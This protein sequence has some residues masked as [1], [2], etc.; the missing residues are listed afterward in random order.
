[1]ETLT[2]SQELE[3]DRGLPPAEA[4]IAIDGVT[5]FLI[6]GID[7]AGKSTLSCSLYLALKE[8][9]INVSLHEI[10]PWSDTH[11]PILGNKPWSQRQKRSVIPAEE[12]REYV[13]RFKNDR[14]SIV[15]GD[16]QGRA[17]HQGSYLLKEAAEHGILV[18]RDRTEKDLN[19]PHRQY[20]GA[21]EDLFRQ[22]L[23][24]T[25]IRIRSIRDGQ[26][27]PDGYMGVDGL[28]REPMPDHPKIKQLGEM[29]VELA[30]VRNA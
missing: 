22:L 20:E 29:V 24:P 14:A 28:E 1:M 19:N 7:G 10:D 9:G 30:K 6:G 5:R 23:I 11:D 2:M 4:D 15:L 18:T 26:D 16:M 13:D 3:I 25:S 12:Y 17:E 27:C 8:Q 21:W